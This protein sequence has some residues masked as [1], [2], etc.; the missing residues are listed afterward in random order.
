MFYLFES[1]IGLKRLSDHFWVVDEGVL[2][3][4]ATP[5][6]TPSFLRRDEVVGLGLAYVP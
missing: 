1:N 6:A 4:D 2:L 3:V 5:V